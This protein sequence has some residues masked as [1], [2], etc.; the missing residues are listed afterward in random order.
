MVGS[1]SKIK[2]I[3]EQKSRSR[4]R[5]TMRRNIKQTFSSEGIEID[6]KKKEAIER[7]YLDNKH[8]LEHK[9]EQERQK[10]IDQ[11]LRRVNRSIGRLE[12]QNKNFLNQITSFRRDRVSVGKVSSN[13]MRAL[14]N[15]QS[16]AMLSSQLDGP[17]P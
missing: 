15:L 10:L 17:G 12:R 9:L 5:G 6:P 14:S 3:R 16:R 2:R 11:N 13:N 7:Q 8:A 4:I 1:K